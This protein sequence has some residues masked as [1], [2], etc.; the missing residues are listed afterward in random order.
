MNLKM[1]KYVKFIKMIKRTSKEKL[2]CK[3]QNNHYQINIIYDQIL[4]K[5]QILGV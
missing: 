2:K 3:K 1:R 4:H 5:Y